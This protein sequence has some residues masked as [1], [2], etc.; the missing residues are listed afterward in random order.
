MG[1]R[2]RQHWRLRL[3]VAVVALAAAFVGLGSVLIHVQGLSALHPAPG[4]PE[5]VP[6]GDFP[7]PAPVDPTRAAAMNRAVAALSVGPGAIGPGAFIVRFGGTVNAQSPFGA[8]ISLQGGT[9]VDVQI[10]PDQS[11]AW[12]ALAFPGT[13]LTRTDA[14]EAVKDF[15]GTLTPGY[16]YTGFTA[17]VEVGRGVIVTWS[18]SSGCGPKGADPCGHEGLGYLLP[19]LVAGGK[20]DFNVNLNG[21][22]P[23]SVFRVT[24]AMNRYTLSLLNQ[25]VGLPNSDPGNGLFRFAA[26][27]AFLRA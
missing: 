20:V 26:D 23:S 4:T 10:A 12:V 9:I 17:W 8:S 25:K 21:G 1:Q 27:F 2:R 3:A 18:G 6:V 11:S 5:P 19:Y 15:D 13:R 14:N 22:T 7:A 24:S 16:A